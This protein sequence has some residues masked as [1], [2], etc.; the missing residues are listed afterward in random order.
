MPHYGMKKGKSKVAE[1]P[2]AP[3]PSLPGEFGK[4][5]KKKSKKTGGFGVK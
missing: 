4:K 3:I 2:Y 1:Q 5:D